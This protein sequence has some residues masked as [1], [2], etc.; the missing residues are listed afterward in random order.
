[1]LQACRRS[2]RR[3]V[4]SRWMERKDARYLL[5][6]IT[7]A[8]EEEL[9]GELGSVQV[10]V[11]DSDR[12]VSKFRND[13]AVV[14]L[15]A[16]RA[17]P[18]TIP[19]QQI[20]SFLNRSLGLSLGSVR[21]S[22]FHLAFS[23]SGRCVLVTS[24]RLYYKKCPSIVARLAFFNGTG[25]GSGPLKGSC[26]RGA[27]ELSLPVRECNMDGGWD[28]LQGGCTCK[29]GHEVIEDTCQGMEIIY[30]FNILYCTLSIKY[31]LLHI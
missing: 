5:M 23:Y 11:F 10:H 27:V 22:G 13:Q 20:S 14:R 31:T 2:V 24:I 30:D 9:S 17:F 12:P 16:S 19:P 4:L 25:A 21:H 18:S 28:P 26:V 1:M 7:F 6:D 8:Q 15:L 29:P 3:T